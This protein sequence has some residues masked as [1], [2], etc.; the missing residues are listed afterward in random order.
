[1]Y[2]RYIGKMEDIF[3][4]H[5]ELMAT[6]TDEELGV[7]LSD[8]E[9]YD[10]AEIS[11]A[12]AELRKRGKFDEGKYESILKIIR[13]KL[14]PRPTYY[15]QEAIFFFSSFFSVLYGAILFSLNLKVRQNKWEVIGFG[16]TYTVFIITIRRLFD[17][18]PTAPLLL[19]CAG[20]LILEN[21]I[22]DIY[23]G[24][25]VQYK[26]RPVLIPVLIAAAIL[27]ILIALSFHFDHVSAWMLMF[28]KDKPHN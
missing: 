28:G 27:A 24:K 9:K 8:T 4:S 21:Y 2:I 17:L 10:V 12:V 19:N 7:Y 25:N 13:N 1:L 18:H 14:F 5:K 3:K 11:T 6:K 16:I 23:L 15:S 22:W 26:K 20:G